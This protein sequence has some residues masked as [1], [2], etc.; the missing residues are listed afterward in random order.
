MSAKWFGYRHRLFGIS[1]TSLKTVEHSS[2]CYVQSGRSPQIHALSGKTI[3]N[4]MPPTTDEIHPKECH[5][6]LAL[7]VEL[8]NVT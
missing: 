6:Y 4:E 2:V 1:N 5:S 7:R 8:E 3:V